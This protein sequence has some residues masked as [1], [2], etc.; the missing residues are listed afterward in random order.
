MYTFGGFGRYSFKV[1]ELNLETMVWRRLEVQNQRD[2][3]MTVC[4][5]GMVA[6]GD[7]ALCLFGGYGCGTIRPQPGATYHKDSA[8]PD[9]DNC[10]N[11][12]LH[13]FHIKTCK[14]KGSSVSGAVHAY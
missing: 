12:A 9:A 7:E 13:L 8:Y 6:Y 1:H 4:R 10:W 2:G 5:A 14:F 11:N 3:P